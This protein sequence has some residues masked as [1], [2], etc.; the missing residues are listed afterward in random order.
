M[1]RTAISQP[2][3]EDLAVAAESA[4]NQVG[5]IGFHLELRPGQFTTPG[6]KWR[7][8][9]HDNFADMFSTRHQPKRG[10]DSR[11]GKRPEWKWSQRSLFDQP[12]NLF[13]HLTGQFLIAMENRVHGHNV[14]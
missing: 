7:R 13:Q 5:R 12:G 11:S 8:E 14:E 4:R 9:C 6:N 1:T 3:G 2:A 10:I